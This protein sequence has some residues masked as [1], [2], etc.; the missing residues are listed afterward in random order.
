[1]L[2]CSKNLLPEV[3]KRSC[4]FFIRKSWLSTGQPDFAQNLF[5]VVLGDWTPD[6]SSPDLGNAGIP[7]DRP[8]AAYGVVSTLPVDQSRVTGFGSL[9]ATR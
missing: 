4:F 7:A 6:L 1:M 3:F 2:I 9:M 5:L 8:A